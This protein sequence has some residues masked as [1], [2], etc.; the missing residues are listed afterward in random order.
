[1]TAN[2]LR[3]YDN[4]QS[5]M[6]LATMPKSGVVEYIDL[7]PKVKL[8]G[9]RWTGGRIRIDNPNLHGS[10]VGTRRAA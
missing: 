9:R 7:I 2:L 8:T 6:L 10:F 1:M 4:A 5:A 3:R